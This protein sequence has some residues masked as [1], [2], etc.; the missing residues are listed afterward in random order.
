MRKPLVTGTVT[1]IVMALGVTLVA[2]RP[3]GQGRG[4][5]GGPPPASQQGRNGG[6]G[7]PGGPGPCDPAILKQQLNMTAEQAA[8]FDRITQAEADASKPILDEL[9]TLLGDGPRSGNPPSNETQEK[10]ADLNKQLATIR[11]DAHAQIVQMLTPEQQQQ[12]QTIEQ[13]PGPRGR[14][15]GA[16]P[17]GK[18]PPPDGQRGPRRGGPGRGC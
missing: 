17:D 6:P 13:Q 18:T 10:V 14:R 5:G 3:G 4:P 7:R 8:S 15:A 9:H 1:A 12:M 11:G 2:Q 16:P